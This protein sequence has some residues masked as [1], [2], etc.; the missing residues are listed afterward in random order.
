MMISEHARA[1]R[2][3]AG[4]CCGLGAADPAWALACTVNPQSVSF[5]DY[6][7]VSGAAIDGVGY[8]NLSCDSPTN[9]EVALSTG[10]SGSY[11]SRTMSS[12]GPEM[13][14]NLYTDSG[15]TAVWGD[16]TGGSSTV[17][18]NAGTSADVTVY[19]RIAR[20][21]NLPAGAYSD[22]IVIT[23]TY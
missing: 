15:H 7:S 18:V 21:Q 19:G 22:M 1:L 6:D 13:R 11:A 16:G 23:V 8:V 4:L 14:Y 5:G 10:S 2:L 3:A 20:D 9:V 17:A 12:A